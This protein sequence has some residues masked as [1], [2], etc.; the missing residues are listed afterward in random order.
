MSATG[1]LEFARGPLER[2]PADLA[3]V[4]V[5]VDERPFRGGAGRVDWRLCSLLSELALE[6][7][8]SGA[9]GEA[10]LLPGIGRLAVGRIL[11]IGAGAR[12]ELDAGRVRELVRTAVERSLELGARRVALPALG[13]RDEEW[14]RFAEALLAGLSD[15]LTSGAEGASIELRMDVSAGAA[16]P[17]LRALKSARLGANGGRVRIQLPGHLPEPLDARPEASR[18]H[19]GADPAGSGPPVRGP[20]SPVSGRY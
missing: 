2:I 15:A 20:I 6:G 18:P 17:T 10:I 14:P 8:L 9:L 5:T 4:A 11:V 19:Q 16:G 12:A 7:H 1:V 3:V 13:F